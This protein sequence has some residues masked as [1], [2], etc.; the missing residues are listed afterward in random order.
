MYL[1]NYFLPILKNN[2]SEA[3][4]KSHQL[5]LRVGMIKQSSSGIYSWLPMGFKI[6]KKIEN[7]VREEQNKIGAQELLMPT[8]QSAEIWK[9]SGRYND[10]GDEMLRIKDR[11]GREMLYGPTNEE[12]ITEI[13]RSAIKSYKLLPQLLY[14]IQW[15]FRDELRPRFGI[16]RCR[17]FLMKDAYS[18]DLNDDDAVLS[19]NKMF[20]AYLKTF[21]RLEL[22]AIPMAADT[23]PIGG[24]L[25][26]EFVILAES[27]ESKIF[28]D[29]RIFDIKTEK[30]SL[31]NVSLKNMRNEFEKYYA[32][33]DDKFN[34]KDFESKV[35]KNNRL[36]TKGIEVGHIFYF[37]DKYSKALKASV[38]LQDGKKTD[39]KMGSYGIGVSRLVGA[40]IEAKFNNNIMKWPY[41]ISPFDVAVIPMINKNDD[42]NLIKAENIYNKLKKSNIDVLLDD[43]DENISSKL[44]KFNLIGVPY[45]II[46]GKNSEQD[47][48]EFKEIDK[49]AKQLS[50]NEIIKILTTKKK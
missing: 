42:T 22:S 7:I 41:S 30:Y 6:M 34:N 33:T 43:T 23:G 14:H 31:T 26:H 15:K 46:L 29:K 10:Y 25:S 16:M 44:K 28:A 12:L 9:E 20:L 1:S 27:G 21:Q 40:I 2:P 24:N 5:M 38:D 50:I 13:F 49:E 37:G 18:F 47:L 36:I 35:L 48:L 8:I 3:Q 11:Q 4:I 19:Y 32:V 17:E 45:Q 39:V